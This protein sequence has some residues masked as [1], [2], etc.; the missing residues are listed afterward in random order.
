MNTWLN[1]GTAIVI[2]LTGFIFGYT[3]RGIIE[4]ELKKDELDYQNLVLIVI[5]LG[6]L[7]SV[8]YELANPEYHT[9]PLIHGLMGVVAGYFFKKKK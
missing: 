1:I 3:G 7:A 5:C 9:N 4:K 2:F 8:L 6:W